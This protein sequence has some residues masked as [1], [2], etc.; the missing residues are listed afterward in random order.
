LYLFIFNV[1]VHIFCLLKRIPYYIGTALFV[2]RR[3]ISI[4]SCCF[5]AASAENRKNN[6]EDSRLS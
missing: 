3:P 1:T 4:S 2:L 6:R 5:I